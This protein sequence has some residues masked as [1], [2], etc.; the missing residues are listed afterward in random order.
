MT[1]VR[2]QGQVFR[3]GGI[4]TLENAFGVSRDEHRGRARQRPSG[5]GQH[6]STLDSDSGLRQA[7]SLPVERAGGPS[8]GACV[9]CAERNLTRRAGLST[10]SLPGG[11]RASAPSPAY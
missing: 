8:P 1:G 2:S 6:P 5:G 3:F 11:S 4:A 9:V 7:W 10:R